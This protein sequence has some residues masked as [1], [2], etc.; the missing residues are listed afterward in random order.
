MSTDILLDQA[1]KH[2]AD[3]D[4]IE[5]EIALKRV[6][7]N[8]SQNT[9]AIKLIAELALKCDR[10]E[11]AVNYFEKYMDIAEPD[12]DTS[13]QIA[14]L[15][16]QQ[17]RHHQA[18]ELITHALQLAPNDEKIK[19]KYLQH[20]YNAADMEAF[21]C[22]EFVDNSVQRTRDQIFFHSIIVVFGEEFTDLFANYILPTQLGPGNI[23]A[24]NAETRS[25]YIIY[26][27]PQ[28]SKV[29]KN[30]PA[31]AELNK[32]MDVRI[33]C[34]DLDV[35]ENTGKYHYM[36]QGH[37][38][39]IHKAHWEG[40]RVIF[41]APD[42][43]FSSS[44]FRNLYQ[45][46]KE[47]YK[48]IMIGT[49]RVVKEDFLPLMKE[50]F[51][52]EDTIEAPIKARDLINLVI[53][54][55]HP[56]TRNAIMGAEKTNGWPSQLL[57]EIPGEGILSRNFHLHP[58][59]VHP[60]ELSV[61][62]GTVDDDCVRN[63]CKNIEEVYI[64]RD[65]DEMTGFDL[66]RKKV[67]TI[68]LNDP[69]NIGYTAAW[70]KDHA[71]EFHW[72]YF[73]HE[74]RFHNGKSGPLWE[75]FS[76]EAAE[77]VTEIKNAGNNEDE[78]FFPEVLADYDLHFPPL[79]IDSVCF[80][81]TSKCNLSCV[82]CPQHWNEDKGS[83]M[84]DKLLRRILDYIKE[85]DV[86]QSTIGFYGE[87]LISKNWLRICEELLNEEV[88]LNICSNFNMKLSTED[89]RV[90][91]R[92]QHLQLSIDSSDSEMLKAI[93]PPA[94]LARMLHNMHKI[95]ATA[96]A[97]D[98]PAPIFQ[99]A[100]TLSDRIASQL[101]DLVAL[102]SSNNVPQISCNELVY[103]DDRQLPLNSIFNLKGNEFRTAI[104]QINKA[105]KLAE[106]H[107][108]RMSVLPAW[109]DM[110]QSRLA[111]D[112]AM[113]EFGVELNIA[114]TPVRLCEK[115]NNIQGEGRMYQQKKA[116]PGP[117]ETRACL[118]PWNSAYV[119][120]NGDLHSCCIRGQVMGRVDD[121][122]S[123]RKAMH[124]AD[125]TDLRKQLITG[126]ITDPAC[127]NCHITYIIP[128]RELKRRVA[129]MIRSSMGK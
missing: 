79:T 11:I 120:P 34:V 66:S 127:L 46:T 81:P 119:M 37:K 56:D 65:S 84:D 3:K 5:A 7:K 41:L 20:A 82:Y 47:G 105:R 108:I 24:L 40:A 126:N 71:D 75:N 104:E 88:S 30:S 62:H 58:L 42:G 91:S 1:A 59:M 53:K 2:L 94:N 16:D 68:E 76:L 80:Q 122:T 107:D 22:E 70:A 38:H 73:E 29:I 12:L 114:A 55:L 51:F 49:M 95:R 28:D 26:T 103:F 83:E 25:L 44:T 33:Y 121:E 125:Y 14:E 128:V 93:R 21:P 92:F 13:L 45:R 4:Y 115:M 86:I 54:N 18:G 116:V 78:H 111:E 85:N 117:G 57:W 90:L 27:T 109:D 106:K 60:E 69:F 39:A 98:R 129:N 50:R 23:E 97:D 77:L 102:A 74:I 35:I 64:T 101:P 32:I 89:C 87:T 31:F 19:K 123:I 72:Q 113:E 112:R 36:V 10:P 110:V 43:V 6:L 124:S 17:E 61:F 9:L 8:E 15:F 99:W 48:A 63:I 52:A 118:F 67:R 96:I 100:C